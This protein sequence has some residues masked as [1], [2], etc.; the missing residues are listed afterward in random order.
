MLGKLNPSTTHTH[1]SHNIFYQT[2]LGHFESL[3]LNCRYNL[4]LVKRIDKDLFR[5]FELRIFGCEQPCP[6][7]PTNRV[8]QC[9]RFLERKLKKI[10]CFLSSFRLKCHFQ[11]A[12]WVLKGHLTFYSEPANLLQKTMLCVPSTL[13]FMLR[14][15][16]WQ[17]TQ[18]VIRQIWRCLLI[19]I[20]KI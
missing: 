6:P 19:C 11:L 10:T 3:L 18:L 15:K 5:T 1:A 16:K 20:I 7:T 8:S 2:S 14:W 4:L 12:F 17:T 13:L 9:W